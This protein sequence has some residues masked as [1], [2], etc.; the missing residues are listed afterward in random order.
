MEGIFTM[1]MTKLK[2]VA[3][4]NPGDLI[5]ARDSQK[6]VPVQHCI[7]LKVGEIDLFMDTDFEGFYRAVSQ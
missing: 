4:I 3:T 1:E 5:K 7:G 2:A 6:C